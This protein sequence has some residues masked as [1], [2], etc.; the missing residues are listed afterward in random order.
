MRVLGFLFSVT[1]TGVCVGFAV[2]HLTGNSMAA[3]LLGVATSV[4]IVSIVLGIDTFLKR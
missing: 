1:M 4:M 2:Y 3:E